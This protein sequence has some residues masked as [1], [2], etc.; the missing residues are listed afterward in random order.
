[1]RWPECWMQHVYNST[2]LTVQYEKQRKNREKLWLNKSAGWKNGMKMNKFA[3][4]IPNKKNSSDSGGVSLHLLHSSATHFHLIGNIISTSQPLKAPLEIKE[5]ATF[6]HNNDYVYHGN[7]FY[8][9]CTLCCFEFVIFFSVLQDRHVSELF[10]R[11][12]DWHILMQVVFVDLIKAQIQYICNRSSSN[13]YK[14]FF[15]FA[16]VN[17]KHDWSSK[18]KREFSNFL[19]RI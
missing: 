6:K 1:M 3:G 8:A 18:W 15:S 12:H 17:K 19:M 4:G 7:V 9:A 16:K 2:G 10:N 13:I 14:M 11:L 5:A